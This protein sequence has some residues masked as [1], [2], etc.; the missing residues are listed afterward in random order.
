M[1]TLT[2]ARDDK[3][4]FVAYRDMPT[5]EQLTDLVALLGDAVSAVEDLVTL[6][7]LAAGGTQDVY[8]ATVH[9]L[10]RDPLE[11]S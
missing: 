8:D 3:G 4:R 9:Y 1:T 2:R 10:G 5:D 7:R 6:R 11:N